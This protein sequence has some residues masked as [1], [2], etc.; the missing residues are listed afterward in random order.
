MD[1]TICLCFLPI[2][3]RLTLRREPWKTMIRCRPGSL[4]PTWFGVALGVAHTLCLSPRMEPESDPGS[5]PEPYRVHRHCPE[6]VLLVTFHKA[7]HTKGPNGGR[8][9]VRVSGGD[10]QPESCR[11]VPHAAMRRAR[12]SADWQ[13]TSGWSRHGALCLGHAINFL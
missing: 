4:Q 7:G 6:C 2:T 9:R 11:S 3:L 5:G 10:F 12:L 8:P 13:P 1:G